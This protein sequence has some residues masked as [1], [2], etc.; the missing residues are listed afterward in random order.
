[1]ARGHA[2]L[3]PRHEG[4]P[5]GLINLDQTLPGPLQ[6]EFQA[7]RIVQA[8][9]AARADAEPPGDKLPHH[10]PVPVGQTGSNCGRQLLDRC[11]QLR[12]LFLTESGGKPPDCSKIKAP[13]PPSPKTAAQRPMV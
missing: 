8:T 12:L 6:D 4:I 7:V 5:F 3:E 2:G 1:M 13:G 10:L 11:L 9:A